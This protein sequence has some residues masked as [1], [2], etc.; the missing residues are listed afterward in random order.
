M[1]HHQAG[2]ITVRHLTDE[3]LAGVSGGV[4]VV[5]IVLRSA[6]LMRGIAYPCLSIDSPVTIREGFICNR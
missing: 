2:N 3:E 4:T 1:D 6:A 5:D